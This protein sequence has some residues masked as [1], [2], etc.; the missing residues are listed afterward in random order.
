MIKHYFKPAWW[1]RNP[2]LQTIY[3]KFAGGKREVYTRKEIFELSDGDFLDCRW[4]GGDVGPIVI[5]LHGLEGSVESHYAKG[6]LQAAQQR[7]WRAVVVH[8]RSCGEN[9][10]RLPRGYHSGDTSD[11]QEFIT[12]LKAKEPHT[13]MMAIGYSM[14]GNVLLKWL[15]ETRGTSPLMAAVAVSVPF[16]LHVAS[17]RIRK[18]IS[19]QYQKYFLKPL[20]EKLLCKIA[21]HQ[22]QIDPSSV[23]AVQSIYDFDDS[24]TA[25]LHGF[26]SAMDYYLQ[27]SS[28]YFMNSIQVPTLV[29][30]AKDDPFMSPALI[31]SRDEVSP[32]VKLEIYEQ[33][34]HVGFVSGWNPFNPQYWLEQRIPAYF[35]E[36][37]HL[38]RKPW[39]IA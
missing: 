30:H 23:M 13:P 17:D 6:M 15:G 18:G 35:E 2:H 9:L 14:G 7:G 36:Q 27:S 11:V 25:P 34:G 3:A 26:K 4:A 29:I 31:P 1:L 5:I 22:L 32:Y 24:F 8:F 21:Q 20:R 38:S 16:E 39:R 19:S 33:G 12:A 37:L 10:N 28:R